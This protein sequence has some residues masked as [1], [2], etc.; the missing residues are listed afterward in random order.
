MEL[1]ALGGVVS[2]SGYDADKIFCEYKGNPLTV[3]AKFLFPVIKKVTKVNVKH[4][5]QKALTVA[6]KH[7]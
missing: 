6:D 3:D 5:Q 4:L 7:R 1:F 2:T